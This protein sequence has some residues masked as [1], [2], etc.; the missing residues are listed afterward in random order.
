MT[1]LLKQIYFLSIQILIVFSAEKITFSQDKKEKIPSLDKN[2]SLQVPNQGKKEAKDLT[3]TETIRAEIKPFKINLTLK[4]F[5]EDID[6]QSL[7]IKT[8]YWSDLRVVQSPKQG[9]MV[10][11]DEILVQL[12][13]EKI[14][15]QIHNLSHE[16]RLLEIDFQILEVELKLAESLVPLEM[17]AIELNEKYVQEDFKRFKNQDLPFQKRSLQM[18]LKRVQD[19]L[20]YSQEELNQLEKMYQED[21]LTEETE[22]IILQRAKNQVDYAK[23]SVESAQKNFEDFNTIQAPRSQKAMQD[24][25]NREKLLFS[26]QRKTTPA[27][28][29]LIK[30]K[31]VKM[32]QGKKILLKNKRDLEQDLKNM[33]LKSPVDGKVY[34][35]TFER[36]KWSGTLPLKNKLQEGGNLKA[37][38]EILTVCPSKRFKAIVEIPEK[39]L[40]LVQKSLIGKLIFSSLPE[41]KI[42]AKIESVSESPHSPN[43]YHA[44][45][46]FTLPKGFNNPVPG[47]ACSFTFVAYEKKSAITL[48]A[49]FVFKD[50]YDPEIL[51]VYVLNKS[52]KSRKKRV[53]VG[54]QAGDTLEILRGITMRDKVLKEKPKY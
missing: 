53:D 47:T 23:F 24:S 54:K 9:R 46:A 20:L 17:E 42:N 14:R 28:V 39:D 50:D 2:V 36:G 29:K 4:G 8:N 18:N 40:Y 12:D 49:K 13:Q 10:K 37:Y 26:A 48:P 19:Y 41:E 31:L 25:F 44:I 6:A 16:L 27:E 51:Y 34:W 43:K 33:T 5:I 35:G 38:E 21:D 22:E 30:L 11:K 3:E 52:G 15:Q 7:A 32:E 1:F 45:L